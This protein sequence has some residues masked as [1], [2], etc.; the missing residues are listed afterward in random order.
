MSKRFTDT[1]K[2]KK[3]YFRNLS[4]TH[5]LFWNYINDN[6]NHAGIWEVDFGLA[7]YQLGI[8]LDEEDIKNIF[9]ER[10]TILDNG[11]KWFIN[12]FVEFQYSEL[13]QNNNAHVSVAKILSK[14]GLLG[15]A[16][17]PL[18]SPCSGDK[19]KD[20]DKAKDKELV[21]E[22]D[23]VKDYSNSLSPSQFCEKHQLKYKEAYCPVCLKEFRT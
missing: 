9:C 16:G 14:H 23:K 17:Q 1:D 8:E 22:K 5:K 3:K 11:E 4:S 7:S 10:I 6:C 21:K 19:D 12:D 15:G 20:Q 18:A 13:K 2:W